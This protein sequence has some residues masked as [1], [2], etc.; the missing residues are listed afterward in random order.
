[1]RRWNATGILF[2]F[3]A[4]VSAQFLLARYAAVF[5]L[6]FFN[7]V[8]P[9]TDE[10]VI[11]KIERLL[12][13]CR[14]RPRQIVVME[15]RRTDLKNLGAYFTGF[16]R[17]ARIVVFRTVLNKIEIHR[18]EGIVAR[19]VAYAKMNTVT[20]GFVLAVVTFWLPAF[21]ATYA[22]LTISWFFHGLKL[23]LSLSAVN[24]LIVLLLVA[25]VFG[26]FLKPIYNLFLWQKVFKADRFAS[27][28]VGIDNYT[29][30]LFLQ[31]DH[32]GCTLLGDPFYE[33]FH[34]SS[35]SVLKR[36]SM[37]NP[38]LRGPLAARKSLERRDSFGH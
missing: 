15:D 23:N 27:E 7:R 26:F 34:S 33:A 3:T 1:L 30:S 20:N 29:A 36:I 28:R 4:L 10:L 38:N 35:P 9:I 2:I 25:P 22:F 21:L 11:Q 17:S 32:I 5:I 31:H 18:L 37:L 12:S 16:G 14:M 24:C 19:L 6:P 8:T 13:E